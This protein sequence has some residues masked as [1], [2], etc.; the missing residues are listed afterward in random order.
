M[1]VNGKDEKIRFEGFHVPEAF[2][3]C[4]KFFGRVEVF[5]RIPVHAGEVVQSRQVSA[6]VVV[7]LR[8]KPLLNA[9]ALR[10]SR[11]PRDRS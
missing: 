9:F 11:C 1:Y 4:L 10:N 8:R 5:W 7:R 2:R 3:R 6:V